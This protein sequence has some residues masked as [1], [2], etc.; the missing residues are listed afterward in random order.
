MTESV[1]LTKFV[2]I[3]FSYR[4]YSLINIA[5]ILKLRKILTRKKNTRTRINISQCGVRVANGL[6]APH[7]ASEPSGTRMADESI[8][9]YGRE[10][11]CESIVADVVELEIEI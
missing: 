1:V 3:G 5:H 9:S 2:I 8:R 10:E 7:G 4:G 6:I 11:T